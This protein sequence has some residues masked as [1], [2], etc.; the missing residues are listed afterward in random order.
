MKLTEKISASEAVRKIKSGDHVFIHGAA[1]TP[2]VLV[3][4]LAEAAQD[5]QF[6]RLYH[7]H[8]NGAYPLTGAE[9]RGIFS[10]NSFFMGD[11]VRQAVKEKRAD[12]I[13]VALAE[14]PVLLRKRVV[15]LDV[16]LVSVSSPDKNGFVSLGTSVD[17]ALAA[18][19]SAK[20]I[21][22]QVNKYLPRT[23]GD[24]VLHLRDIDYIVEGD[25]P[26]PAGAYNEPSPE[27][28][29]IGRHVAAL[30]PDGATLQ[31]GIGSMPNAVLSCLTGHKNLGIHTEM[32]SDG[33]LP[34]LDS[35]VVNNHFKKVLPGRTVTSFVMGSN[36]LYE[37]VD[38]N[39]AL[40]FKDIA[41]VNDPVIIARNPRVV[42]INSALE[43][44][45]SGQ[46]CADSIGTQMFS[47]VG[48]QMDFM[49]G[50]AH[51]TD[52]IP[53][54]AMCSRTSKG[55][56]KIASTLRV[57]AGVTVTRSQAHWI[58]TEYGAVDL[59]GKNLAERAR[60]LISIAHPDDREALEKAWR[61]R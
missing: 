22:A 55:I 13:P 11:N 38:D 6:V 19:Q 32:F 45:L 3:G 20:I 12:Y 50:A 43:V 5:L 56:S 36:K 9:F 51:S 60:L 34:L 14:L 37:F 59:Y 4:A 48:G 29:E 8:L 23:H 40:V 30:V 41:W 61:E 17:V 33:L 16:A 25:M 52:G 35:G 54:I 15:P 27:E 31:M 10:D 53:I 46:V 24:G 26:L 44:D 28:M 18:V 7:L 1:A 42:A 21:I 2:Q 39:L 58:V 57:G 47:G 49:L